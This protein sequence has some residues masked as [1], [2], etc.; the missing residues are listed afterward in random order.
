MAAMHCMH[1][2]AKVVELFCGMGLRHLPVVDCEGGQVVGMITRK[3]VH[4][5]IP[6]L[7]QK[8]HMPDYTASPT[9][10]LF[11]EPSPTSSVPHHMAASQATGSPGTGL[12]RLFGP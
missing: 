1:T 11:D 4:D 12:G 2:Y 7:R 6:V 10:S 5:E 9:S 3:D 8:V